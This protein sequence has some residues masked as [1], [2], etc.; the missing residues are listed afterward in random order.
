MVWK[1]S[2][3]QIKCF[4][5]VYAYFFITRVEVT[6]PNNN[7]H[8]QL[9]LNELFLTPEY[10]NK[11]SR[12]RVKCC[13]T[14]CWSLMWAGIPSPKLSMSNMSVNVNSCLTARSVFIKGW[15]ADSLNVKHQNFKHTF[16]TFSKTPHAAQSSRTRSINYLQ[17][18]QLQMLHIPFPD[19]FCF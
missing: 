6:V 15:C 16:R 19:I 13:M 18:P 1:Q 7:V 11:H 8:H 5:P 14:H 10:I 4:C 9:L 17:L 2:Q 3:P 12:F